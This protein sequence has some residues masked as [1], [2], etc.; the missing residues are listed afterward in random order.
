MT[1]ELILFRH[2]QSVWNDAGLCQ[3]A[4]LEPPLSPAGRAQAA[5]A[6]RALAARREPVNALYSSDQAR[7]LETARF[8]S[9]AVGDLPVRPEPRLRELHQGDWQGLP[10]SEIRARFGDLYR[11][12]YEAPFEVLPPGGETMAA[13][14]RRVFSALDDIAAAHPAGRVIIVSH[15]I[16]LALVRAAA[17][18]AD[19]ARLWDFAPRNCEPSRVLWPLPHS[20]TIPA[21]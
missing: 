12:L 6:A 9:Q 10:F 15:E 20:V 18:G 4:A 19:L 7:A 11:R 1:V 2:G 8:L 5:F 3:G 17:Y 14:A 16:P 21:P 13:A